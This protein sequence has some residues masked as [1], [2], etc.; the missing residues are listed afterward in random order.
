MPMKALMPPDFQSWVQKIGGK[1]SMQNSTAAQ[2]ANQVYLIADSWELGIF[3]L[4][5]KYFVKSQ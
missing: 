5:N 4:E 1:I 3:D 2:G